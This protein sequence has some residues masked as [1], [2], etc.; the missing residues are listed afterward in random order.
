[1][2]ERYFSI[3]FPEGIVREPVIYSLVKR[4]GLTTN[5]YRASVTAAGGWILASIVGPGDVIDSAI[6]DIKCRGGL[7][8]EGDRSIL[9][10][11]SPPRLSAIKVRLSIPADRVEE[12]TI[13]EMIK[14]F[15]VVI[16]IRQADIGPDSGVME[17]EISGALEAIDRAV[18]FIKKKGI[19]VSPIEG[20]V[21]E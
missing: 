9:S 11:K 8:H 20:N 3:L 14:D 2:S 12:P 6:L 13:S 15:D 18:D 7:P 19:D 17:M 1:M 10:M 4:Y 16:N 5:I 21:I